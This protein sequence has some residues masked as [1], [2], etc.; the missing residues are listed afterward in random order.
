MRRP[1]KNVLDYLVA[2]RFERGCRHNNSDR[3]MHHHVVEPRAK[4]VR[5]I[6]LFHSTSAVRV[7]NGDTQVID[8]EVG[9]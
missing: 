1:I 4:L 6:T 8:G 9:S 3:D 7:S 2:V 5:V